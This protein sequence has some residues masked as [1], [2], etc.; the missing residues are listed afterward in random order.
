[1][2]Y[3]SGQDWQTKPSDRFILKWIKLNLSSRVTGR[4][5]KLYWLR[6]WMVTASSAALGTLAGLVFGLGI[7]WLAGLMA[8]GA[9]VLDGVDGQMARLNNT[10]SPAGAFLDSV[11]DRYP[12]GAMMIGMIVYLMRLPE[13]WSPG[14]VLVLGAAALIGSNLVSYANARADSLGLELGPP[15]L[16]SKG[17]RTTVMV[18]GALGSVVYAPLPLASLVYLAIHPNIVLGVRIYRVFKGRS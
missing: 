15:T 5:V 6:P 8:A 2:T 9:Q 3:I 10:A 4:A 11:L 16:C 12:D 13:A 18:L 7:G 1:L 17:T 14:W